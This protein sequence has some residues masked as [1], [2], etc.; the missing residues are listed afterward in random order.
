[1]SR[2]Q[3]H[4]SDEATSSKPVQKKN[5]KICTPEN[6]QYFDAVLHVL[7]HHMVSLHVIFWRYSQQRSIK[8]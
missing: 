2:L 5:S 1:M 4:S 6:Q 7:Q 8:D 3:W